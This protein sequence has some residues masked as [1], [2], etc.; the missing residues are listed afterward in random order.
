M[1]QRTHV[2]MSTVFFPGLDGLPLPTTPST[3]CQVLDSWM[4]PATEMKS[5]EDQQPSEYASSTF[6]DIGRLLD[7][8]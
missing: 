6:A 5:L 2:V 1:H 3:R 4:T 7:D 8:L